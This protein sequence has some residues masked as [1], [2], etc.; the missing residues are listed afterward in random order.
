MEIMSN[1]IQVKP[2]A[3]MMMIYVYICIILQIENFWIVFLVKSHE[4]WPSYTVL[5]ILVKNEGCD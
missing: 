1:E 3:M 4:K 2:E 5:R